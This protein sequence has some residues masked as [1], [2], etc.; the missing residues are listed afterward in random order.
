MAKH[1]VRTWKKFFGFL[2]C[3]LGVGNGLADAQIPKYDHVVIV[4]FENHSYAN[5]IGNPAA[6]NFNALAASSANFLPASDDPAGVMSGSHAV[7]H[8]SQPN[9]LEFYS[10]SNQGVVQDGRPGTQDE[11]FTTALPFTTPNLGAALRS[12]G[13]SFATYSESLPYVGFD[14][15]SYTTVSGQNQDERK[16]NPVANWMN[17]SNPTPNQLP[18]WVN[19]PFTTFQNL[20]RVRNGFARLPTVSIVVTN[21]QNDMHDGTVNQADAWLKDNILDTYLP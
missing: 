12:S 6:P 2:T 17:D 10:G 18:S 5:I 16:H 19:Q 21:E 3:L 13:Y 7:R 14:G 20:G 9:Y 11:P 15:D 1:S 8:P 4:I